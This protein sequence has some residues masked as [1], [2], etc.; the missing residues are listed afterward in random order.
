MTGPEEFYAYT[1]G[2]PSRLPPTRINPVHHPTG[3]PTQR[4]RLGEALVES[5]VLTQEQLDEL[6]AH[7]AA[8]PSVSRMR[9]GALVVARELATEEDIARGLSRIL[10][11]EYV[12]LPA[13]RPDITAARLLPQMSAEA[14]LAIPI[15][16][17]DTWLQVAVADPTDARLLDRVR[18]LSGRMSI[19]VA[20]AT[21]SAVREAIAYAWGEAPE[22]DTDADHQVDVAEAD[23]DEVEPPTDAAPTVGLSSRQQRRRQKQQGAPV[24]WEYAFLGDALPYEHPNFAEAAQLEA[25]LTAMGADGWEAVGMLAD[26][27][28]VR[29]L[30][31]RPRPV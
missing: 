1:G 13:R 26:G 8:T 22:L 28:R 18:D 21:S 14:M 5:G 20:V 4:M 31:K 17:G 3:Q 27:P 9:L 29:L 12:D 24:Q 10:T 19:S 6:L 11:L 23:D 30:L 16:A 15:A 2:V 7:Q 25:R